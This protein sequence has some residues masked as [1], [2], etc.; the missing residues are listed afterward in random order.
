MPDSVAEELDRHGED[1][2]LGT[3]D[4]TS[5]DVGTDDSGLVAVD[6]VVRAG[7]VALFGWGLVDAFTREMSSAS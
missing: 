7:G 2:M 5:E 3:R 1:D 4:D 6:G